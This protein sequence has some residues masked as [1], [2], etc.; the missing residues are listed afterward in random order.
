MSLQTSHPFEKSSPSLAFRNLRY[1]VTEYSKL[2]WPSKA[3]LHRVNGSFCAGTLNGV[4]GP[5]G[6][7]KTTLL[8]CLSGTQASGLTA[9]SQLFL[10]RSVSAKSYFIEQHISESIEGALTVRQ[11]LQYA[12]LFKN[13]LAQRHRM[14]GHIGSIASQLLLRQ[15]ILNQPF[16]VCSG[17]EQRRIATAQE[18]MA[19]EKPSFLFVDE[20]T[21]GE[22]EPTKHKMITKPS[23]EP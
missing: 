2:R 8:R 15:S 4:L 12:F 20:P 18:L 3:L 7:S 17:G 1:E 23:F 6:A 22:F 16:A 10:S 21:T 19:L 11:I 14:E 5:S 13:G 9:D